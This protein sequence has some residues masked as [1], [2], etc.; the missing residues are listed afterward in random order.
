[1][2]S[3]LSFGSPFLLWALLALP[4]LW[5][6][7]KLFPP[8]P[9]KVFLASFRLL[10]D[11][12]DKSA[13]SSS[14]P[15]WLLILRL[16][17]VAFLIIALSKPVLNKSSDANIPDNNTPLLLMI[18]NSWASAE[19]WD[20]IQTQAMILIGQAERQAK[21]I[22]IITTT[23]NTPNGDARYQ[24]P[25]TATQAKS[26]IKGAQP[27]PWPLTNSSLEAFT[28]DQK[29]SFEIHFLSSGILSKEFIKAFNL[30][31]KNGS[32][33][34]YKPRDKDLPVLLKLARFKQDQITVSI[35]TASVSSRSYTAQLRNSKQRVLDE[36][37]I[38]KGDNTASFDLPANI[39]KQAQ[40]V[41]IKGMQNAGS[42]LILNTNLKTSL[43]GVLTGGQESRKASLISP[44]FY[45]E[46][47]IEPFATFLQG[48][49][50]AL[51][52][53]NPNIIVLPDI[54]G[55]TP[56]DL[57]KLERFAQNGGVILRFAGP[58]MLNVQTPL[59]PVPLRSGGRTLDSTLSWDSPLK[60][61]AFPP[62]SPFAGLDIDEDIVVAQQIL[63][64]PSLNLDKH[65]WA[66]LED[67][68][69]LI[70]ANTIGDGL[71]VM[72]HTTAT[73]EWSNFVLSGLFPKIMQKISGMSSTNTQFDFSADESATLSPF[74]AKF[75]LNGFGKKSS[76]PS[77]MRP[78][79]ATDI[80]NLQ[81]SSQAP[82]GLYSNQGESYALNISDTFETL[83]SSSG[84][85]QNIIVRSYATFEERPLMPFFLYLAF[86]L[87][88]IDIAVM[89]GMRMSLS[90]MVKTGASLVFCAAILPNPVLASDNTNAL[91]FANGLYLAFIKTGNASLDSTAQKGLS[92]LKSILTARTSIEPD[93][94]H[95]ITLSR[96]DIS[97]FPLIYWPIKSQ[98]TILSEVEY[99]KIQ[100]YLDNGG[101]IFVDVLSSRS[102]DVSGMLK[103]LLSPLSIP[104]LIPAPD[105]HVLRK[106]FYLLDTFSGLRDAPV[107]V[108]ALSAKG[109]DGVSSIMIG[110]HDFISAW[111]GDS[112]SLYSNEQEMA[113]RFGVNLVM[114][115]L[116]GNYKAD[117]VH[118][119]FILKRIGE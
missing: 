21:P 108:E 87:L 39:I 17:F 37:T 11:L 7:L 82:P 25:I 91:K 3:G 46:K 47:A 23:S 59:T 56:Y 70:T 83:S 65:V 15:L 111:A 58:N 33:Y 71:L 51:L 12:K 76:P 45:I 57:G 78:I 26:I 68:T 75:T 4:A 116:A 28:K 113:Y 107:W 35:D 110:S 43:F 42:T 90:S 69:P 109:R 55:M 117:Q 74:E 22:H 72:I 29:K 38:E 31:D 24:G 48:N 100:H 77:L 114:Y 106:S 94:V 54:S 9:K 115:A 36:V 30:L 53:K 52:D 6:I 112:D 79:P 16:C 63:A 64:Q 99:K 5:L 98:N 104:A 97:F 93:G 50:D 95:G 96:D 102:G 19:N 32:I 44:S 13:Q 20:Q 62:N 49:L 103:P 80:T 27:H 1:M 8:A 41:T 118:I 81:I 40:F 18:D 88:L 101:T 60:L 73:P 66:K 86:I 34:L 10:K 85:D 119:P 89:I 2:L 105:E 14:I 92:N 84:L 61:A 67:D